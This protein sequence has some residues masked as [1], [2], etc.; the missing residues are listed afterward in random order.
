M[1]M[2][3]SGEMEKY[4]CKTSTGFNHLKENKCCQDHSCVYHDEQRTIVTACDGHGGRMYVRSHLGSIFASRALQKVFGTFDEGVWEKMDKTDVADKLRLEILCEW[5]SL[6]ES[7]LSQYA[8]S[9]DELSALN[10]EEQ[11]KLK[12]SPTRAYGTTLNGAMVLGNRL[13]CASLGDGGVFVLRDEQ[14][15]E[16]FPASEDDPVANITYSMCQEDAFDHL[17]VDVVDFAEADGVLVCTDGTINPYRSLDNFNDSFVRPIVNK[18]HRGNALEVSNFLD[19]LGSEVGIG[20]D[21]SLGVILNATAK[22]N[23]TQTTDK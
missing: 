5:N 19:K 9:P 1:W 3:G 22:S 14:L 15:E 11:F 18:L 4:F 7:D 8:I 2:I 12:M 21:V 17:N 20:D 10:D 13:Y 23:R 16:V 6:V